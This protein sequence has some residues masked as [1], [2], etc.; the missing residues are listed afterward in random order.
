VVTRRLDDTC[1]RTI[2]ARLGEL[3]T[4]LQTLVP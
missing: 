1:E 4:T 2:A 3:R